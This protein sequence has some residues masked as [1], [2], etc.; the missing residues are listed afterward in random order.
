MTIFSVHKRFELKNAEG[1]VILTCEPFAITDERFVLLRGENGS[2]KSVFIK[3]LTGNLPNSLTSTD[4]KILTVGGEHYVA[5]NY[6]AS[7]AAGLV[8]VFQDDDLISTFKVVDHFF[9]QHSQNLNRNYIVLLFQI[10]FNVVMTPV[11]VAY[12]VIRQFLDPRV[13]IVIDRFLSFNPDWNAKKEISDNASSMFVEFGLDEAK[14]KDVLQKK[15]T[16]L[17]GGA[18]AM[19]KLCNA[20]LNKNIRVLILDEAFSGVQKETWSK[21]IDALKKRAV[22]ENFTIINVSHNEEECSYW[23][24][25]GELKIDDGTL[26]YARTN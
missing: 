7:K 26:Y 5:N 17:F 19:T 20:I 15:P 16:E 2:G 9:L 3:F 24:A 25:E 10:F 8:A 21:C 12:I 22:T 23:K 13:V 1:E 18:R 11:V 14:V 6:S 4:N